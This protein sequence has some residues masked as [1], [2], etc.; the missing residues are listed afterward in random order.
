MKV[1]RTA[2]LL[3]AVSL[4]LGCG[5]AP[6]Y[7]GIVA[8]LV[9]APRVSAT[10]MV[11]STAA[12]DII[13]LTRP[14]RPRRPRSVPTQPAPTQM[15][16]A[17]S[18][19]L[20]S[21]NPTNYNQPADYNGDGRADVALITSTGVAIAYGQ[22]DGSFSQTPTL[23]ELAVSSPQA[24]IPGDFDGDGRADMI[25]VS[26][27]GMGSTYTPVMNA[28]GGT[29]RVGASVPFAQLTYGRIATGDFDGDGHLDFVI[30]YQSSG[31][32]TGVLL[33]FR[34]HGD[35]TFDDGRPIGAGNYAL[36][37]ASADVNGDGHPDLVYRDRS[38]PSYTDQVRV[39]LNDGHGNF[40]DY[41]PSG[42]VG[43]EGPF[44]LADLDGDGKLDM[45]AAAQGIG[46]EF[47]GGG[48][49][50][51][52]S[53][54]KGIDLGDLFLLSAPFLAG[55][56]DGDGIMDLAVFR[57][58]AGP[59]QML[60][61]WNDGTG[62]LTPLVVPCDSTFSAYA[63]DVNGDGIAD[64]VEPGVTLLGR[65][66]RNIEGTAPMYPLGP[67]TITAA[68][69]DGDGVPEVLVSGTY[70]TQGSLFKMKSD[71]SFKRLA[72]TPP[73]GFL[74]DDING[75]GKADL[76]GLDHRV[77][78]LI[79]WEGDG[80][81]N[82]T[83]IITQV[84]VPM[85]GVQSSDVFFRDMDG[86]GHLDIVMSGS[87]LYGKGGFQFDVVPV[88]TAGIIGYENAFVIG[89]F[90]G[91][92]ILDL[93][94]REG[95][96]FGLGNR[97]FASVNHVATG[98]PANIFYVV[99]QVVDWNGDGKDDLIIGDSNS[100]QIAF[101]LSLGRSGFSMGQTLSVG[102]TNNDYVGT[103]VLGDFNGDGRIDIAVGYLYRAIASVFINTGTGSYDVTR[104]AIG[105]MPIQ[106]LVADVNGDGKP[107]LVFFDLPLD[108]KWPNAV[109]LVH[110]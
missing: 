96:L 84:N 49:G 13:S 56:F 47:K 107:D 65:Y 63:A 34:G 78:Q 26:M 33:L 21:G 14:S 43:V 11:D 57:V 86:D 98:I 109:A 108:Y 29:F 48:D 83:H 87:I 3:L 28:G 110:R 24:I 36:Q 93:A 17:P 59:Y 74:L 102:E 51:F 41:V 39:M 68:D 73:G 94:T 81:G 2:V 25:V 67:G 64:I 104:Y 35:G 27:E 103:V 52:V 70:S 69:V 44:V 16:R 42:I 99:P 46:Y 101:Y 60:I 62:N 37:V 55:D 75:D 77:D 61:L 53:N 89:D 80:T 50:T 45:F 8:N 82:F 20:Y 100:N 71:G 72:L 76:I 95:V 5:T 38:Y 10:S 85:A 15:F 88:P 18:A 90:D 22:S 12:A 58:T 6:R 9:Q 97:S 32:G 105:D 106:S 30:G 4:I 1:W 7:P 40:T 54:G 19:Y 23:A 92:G 79:I 66:D 91:D 31:T